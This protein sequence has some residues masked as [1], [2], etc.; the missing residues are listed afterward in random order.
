MEHLLLVCPPVTVPAAVVMEHPEFDENSR[1]SMTKAADT[2]TDEHTSS[3]H[4]IPTRV[5]STYCELKCPRWS[6]GILILWV[7]QH[8]DDGVEALMERTRPKV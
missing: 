5:E 2:V 1:C 6:R 8:I 7:Y 4:P 3:R